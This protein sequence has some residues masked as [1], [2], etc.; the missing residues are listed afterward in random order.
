MTRRVLS[1]DQARSSI[2][3]IQSIIDG[4]LR[5]DVQRL[6]QLLRELGD[7]DVWDGPLAAQFRGTTSPQARAELDQ[8][9]QQ[10]DALRGHA[11]QVTGAIMAAGGGR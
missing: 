10:L 2:Q 6:S 9:V 1:S 5:S 7:P 4:S 11:Q 8:L 3:G